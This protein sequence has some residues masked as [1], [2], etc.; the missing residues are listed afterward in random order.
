MDQLE[1]YVV[2][3]QEHKVCKL[4]K[5]LYSL[6]QGPKRWHEKSG[7]LIIS[8]GLRVNGSNECIYVKLED[9]IFTIVYIYV[10][11]FLIVSLNIYIVYNVKQL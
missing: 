1:G 4:D 8:H 5:T 10:D 9:N 11:E 2:F 7:N 3:G 6:K